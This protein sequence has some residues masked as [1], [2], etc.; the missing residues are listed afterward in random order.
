MRSERSFRTR[1]VSSAHSQLLLSS[2]KGSLRRARTLQQDTSQVKAL[3]SRALDRQSVLGRP[4]CIPD[5]HRVVERQVRKRCDV[6]CGDGPAPRVAPRVV[7]QAQE[8]NRINFDP[9][10]LLKLA[11]GR[12]ENR[13]ILLNVSTRQPAIGLRTVASDVS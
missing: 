3:A 7:V 6:S 1:G 5:D 12:N 11:S 13:L 9:C 4:Q 10:L 2:G 8:S